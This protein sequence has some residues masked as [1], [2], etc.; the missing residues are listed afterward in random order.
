MTVDVCKLACRGHGY[1]YMATFYGIECYCGSIF[2]DP[3]APASNNAASGPG[4]AVGNNP[5][6]TVDQSNCQAQCQGNTAEYCGGTGAAQVYMDPSFPTSTSVS[7]A[8]NYQYLGCFNNI[9]PG[10]MY[11]QI[12]TPDT[13]TCVQYCGEL[14]FPYAQRNNFDANTGAQSCGCGTEIQSGY[15][16][17]ESTC[18]FYCNGT[19]GAQ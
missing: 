19:E 11:T 18:N 15:Q 13:P 3:N 16:T 6:Q 4:P 10:P 14:G 12:A 7:A 8:S 1:K 5:L 17:D 9:N 2:P